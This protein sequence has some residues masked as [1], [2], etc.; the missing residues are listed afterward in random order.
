[1][2]KITIPTA[3]NID[4]EFES[5]D[6]LQ[7][8]LAWL[9]DI[10]IISAYLIVVYNILDYY[11]GNEYYGNDLPLLYNIS[12]WETIVFVPALVYHLVCELMMNGQTPGKKICRIKVI[13][14]TGGRPSLYQFLL[15]WLTRFVDFTFTMTLGAAI[16]YLTNKKNQRLGDM[17]AG[18]MVIKTKLLSSLTETIFTEL[19]D[20][21]QARYNRVLELS[22]RDMNT[23][24]TILNGYY[25]GKAGSSSLI[26]RTADAIRSALEIKEWEENVQFL[27]NILKDYNHLAGKQ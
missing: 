6:F 17:A 14:E 4:L 8:T 9:I 19:S 7:R 15:R 3:F 11:E 10:A 23:I 20:T 2:E 25:S 26:D 27:E 5:A 16:S 13:S 21:Y 22:D 1:M 18:T 12:A 24:K